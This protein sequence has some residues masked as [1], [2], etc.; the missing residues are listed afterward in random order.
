[1]RKVQDD[2]IHMEIKLR[3][4][5]DV[6]PIAV[7]VNQLG[8]FNARKRERGHQKDGRRASSLQ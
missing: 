5:P 4:D 2:G 6:A 1:V 8:N 3:A 7:H